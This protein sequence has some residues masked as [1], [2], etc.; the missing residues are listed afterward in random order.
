MSQATF[1][2]VCALIGAAIVGVGALTAPAP[3]DRC[4]EIL[5]QTKAMSSHPT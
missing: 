2:V 3:Y 4:H 1:L 5:Q